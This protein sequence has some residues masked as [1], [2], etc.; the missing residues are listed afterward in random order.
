MRPHG[1][2]SPPAVTGASV[3]SRPRTPYVRCFVLSP[4][5]HASP[6][7]HPEEKDEKSTKRLRQPEL[8]ALNW[9]LPAINAWR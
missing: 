4:H 1:P 8:P 7:S 5:I 3:S 9:R 6:E 2:P